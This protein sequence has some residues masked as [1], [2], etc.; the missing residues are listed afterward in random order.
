MPFRILINV[1]ALARKSARTFCTPMSSDGFAEGSEC[2]SELGTEELRLLPRGEVTALVGLVEVDQVAIGAPGP[3]L[4]GSVALPR[5]DRDRHRE[6]DLSGHL[7]AR[8][9]RTA[10][11]VLPVQPPR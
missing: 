10:S 7:R 5:K 9:S 3:A 1:A 8:K 11:A 2:R 4:R 6:R